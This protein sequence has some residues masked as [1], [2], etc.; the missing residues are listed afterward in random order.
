MKELER[1]KNALTSK[2]QPKYSK[3]KGICKEL[4]SLN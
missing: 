4:A 3:V 1:T 2:M